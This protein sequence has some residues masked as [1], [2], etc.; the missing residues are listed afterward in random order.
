[1]LRLADAVEAFDHDVIRFIVAT[2]RRNLMAMVY[3][4]LS[5]V[6]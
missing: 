3:G 5:G 4:V 1:M 2:D 6:S